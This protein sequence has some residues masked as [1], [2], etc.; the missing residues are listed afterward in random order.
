MP[1]SLWRPYE[2]GRT[3]GQPG[4]EHGIVVRDEEHLLGA[5]ITLERDSQSAPFAITCGIY[6]WMLHTRFFT[7]E[8][9]ANSQ[10]EQMKAALSAILEAAEQT[11]A[12]D[13]GRQALFTGIDEFIG[14]YP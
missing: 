1:E 14:N 7:T 12:T 9:E 8:N 3:L 13:G 2:N 5:R 6:G 10:Y 4:S 11:A